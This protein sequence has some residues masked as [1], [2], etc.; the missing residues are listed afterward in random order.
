MAVTYYE[1]SLMKP[2]DCQLPENKVD[3]NSRLILPL[4]MLRKNGYTAGLSALLALNRTLHA[5]N[6]YHLDHQNMV[7]LSHNKAGVI[8]TG[9]KSKRNPEFST[10]RIGDDAYTVKTGDLK[11]G[12][13]W[14][15]A[16]LFYKTFT[17]KIRWEIADYPRLILSTDSDQMVVSS[18]P[19]TDE[20]YIKTDQKYDIRSLD[21]FSP[22]TEGNKEGKIKAA[23]FEWEKKLILEFRII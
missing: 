6:D 8:L 16:T 23:V 18:F 9:Y 17:A 3:G 2:G 12:N 21:G 5:N 19:I 20:N 1:L 4:G 7:Y 22:Y 14:A 13:G 10:F 15:E 11:M